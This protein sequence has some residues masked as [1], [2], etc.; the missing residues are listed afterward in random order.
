M[1]E[2]EYPRKA[3]T[4]SILRDRRPFNCRTKVEGDEAFLAL[5]TIHRNERWIR[6][7]PRQPKV[8][9]HNAGSELAADAL[10]EQ[11]LLGGD[12]NMRVAEFEQAVVDQG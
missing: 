3:L 11:E 5:E 6:L 10:V 1:G 2:H 7:F 8:P 12:R 9:S 4:A